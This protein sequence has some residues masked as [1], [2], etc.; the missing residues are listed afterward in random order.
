MPRF[1]ERVFQ[2]Q[3]DVFINDALQPSETDASRRQRPHLFDEPPENRAPALPFRNDTCKDT[4][5]NGAAQHPWKKSP[6]LRYDPDL[7]HPRF[8]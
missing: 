4:N 3:L 8:L 7:V 6:L 5:E 1:E 2:P